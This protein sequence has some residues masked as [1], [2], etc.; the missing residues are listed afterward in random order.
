MQFADKEYLFLLLLIV[1]Y[2]LWYVLKHHSLYAS[3]RMPGRQ[4]F[5]QMKPTL[6]TYFVHAPFLLRI[7]AFVL[8]VLI[9]ARPQYSNSWQDRETEGI[10][11]M[12]AI[13]V[14]T[15]MLAEDLHPNRV[16]AAKKVAAEFIGG[17]PNDNIGLTLFEGEAFTQCPLTL[18]H[19]V[20]MSF[21]SQI[22]C[23]ILE[24]GTAVGMGIDNAVSKLKDSKAK[25]KV[26]ILLTDGTNNMGDISPLTAADIAKSLGIRIYTIGVGTNGMAP[27]PMAT[28]GGIQYMNVPVEIDEK[29]LRTIAETTGGS[30]YRATSTEKLQDVYRQIDRLERTKMRVNSYSKREE[31]F[32]P[33]ALLLVAVLILESLLRLTLL[34][35][36]P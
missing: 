9:L 29:T 19:P 17:R 23:G 16:E 28:A 18:D 3:L 10:D 13:D 11:I 24:N 4:S 26:V 12:L 30:Y 31:A 5:I 21:L 1:P 35:R 20:L 33:F 34:R 22:R 8:L 36:I 2:I 27:Y 6:R 25:S 14:S 7:L 32:L 15:S